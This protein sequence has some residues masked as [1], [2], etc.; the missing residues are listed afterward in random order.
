MA[1]PKTES[2]FDLIDYRAY[3]DLEDALFDLPA[4]A[5]TV[6]ELK[7]V[8]RI[9]AEVA[10]SKFGAERGDYDALQHIKARVESRNV[11]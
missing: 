11:R 3:H 8:L 10:V 5:F 7:D 6:G 9:T 4:S 1:K 2:Q